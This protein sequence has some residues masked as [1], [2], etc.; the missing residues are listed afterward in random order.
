[1]KKN[2][3]YLSIYIFYIK[4]ENGKIGL[5]YQNFTRGFL[6]LSRSFPLYKED[7]ICNQLCSNLFL[8]FT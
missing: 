6:S 4:S 7:N 1:M 5:K 3:E 2:I 8:S